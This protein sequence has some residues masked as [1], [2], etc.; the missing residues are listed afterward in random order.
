MC[1][2][3]SRP[4]ETTL[5]DQNPRFWGLTDH[6]VICYCT[7]CLCELSFQGPLRASREDLVQSLLLY[8]IVYSNPEAETVSYL[9]NYQFYHG[10]HKY[11]TNQ[12]YIMYECLITRLVRIKYQ[13]ES[14]LDFC[15]AN[16]RR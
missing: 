2:N 9:Q 8:G 16:T 3:E 5:P 11:K 4:L 1:S 6:Q 13:K 15:W 12:I 7:L 14:S 10:R